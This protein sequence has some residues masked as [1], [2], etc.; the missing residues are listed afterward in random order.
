M[1]AKQHVLAVLEENK[2]KNVSGSKLADELSISRNAIWKAIKAL[3]EEGYSIK[4]VPNKGY[5]LS[6]E[7]D[8]LSAQSIHPFLSGRTENLRFEVKKSVSSTNTV[9]KELA[10]KGEAEGKVLIAE[11]QTSGRGRLGRNFYSPAQS[12]IYMSILLR[13]KLTIEDSLFITTSAAVAVAEA[14]EK[15]TGINAVIKWV[16]DIFCNGKKV[17]GILTEAG[18]DF[19]GGGLEYAV[20]GIGINVSIPVEGFPSDLE[21]I[22]TGIFDRK[23]YESN[24]RSRLVAEILNYFWK[25]YD[26]ISQKTFL[27]EYRKRSFLLGQEINILS[28]K[29]TKRALALEIDD[30]A[31]LVVKLPD[32]E[33][34][35]LSSGE[36]SVRAV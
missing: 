3:Q 25:Y 28:G 24:V 2:G 5:C 1:S 33:I 6:D 8:I 21:N 36:V 15:V 34:K 13:P 7:N 9:L 26:N 16:N 20:L 4:A 14:I 31:R 12:G 22:A 29:D 19:E 10:S 35:P 30:N 27:A 18:I 32:G 11:E 23:L 17:C